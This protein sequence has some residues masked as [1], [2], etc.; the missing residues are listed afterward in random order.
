MS[1]KLK[2]PYTQKDRNDFIS[3][4]N[5]KYGLTIEE[6]STALY[7]LKQ[8]E[9]MDNEIPIIDP[10]YEEK[11][12]A[13]EKKETIKKLTRQLEDIDKKRIRAVCEPSMKTESQ[14]WLDFYNEQALQI[15]QVMADL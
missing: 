3:L 2:K 8:N 5:H 13:E 15:R 4:Y 1:Y 12:K 7:A 6:T 14:S 9:I 10:D 11:Q